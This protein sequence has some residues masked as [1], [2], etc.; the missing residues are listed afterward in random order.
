MKDSIVTNKAMRSADEI[1]ERLI[2]L[3][4]ELWER[5]NEREIE[6]FWKINSCLYVPK[7]KI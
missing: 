7:N 5:Q 3:R 6:I 1:V 4:D 2:A